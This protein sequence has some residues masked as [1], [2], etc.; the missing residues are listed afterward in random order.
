MKLNY[1]NKVK[2][3]V[4]DLNTFIRNNYKSLINLF[5][6]KFSEKKKKNKRE[7]TM[8]LLF[9]FKQKNRRLQKYFREI[10][11]LRQ[12]LKNLKLNIT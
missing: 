4:N 10:K 1:I 9:E 6:E 8:N 3:Y 12:N 2:T 5:K 11:Y 7:K